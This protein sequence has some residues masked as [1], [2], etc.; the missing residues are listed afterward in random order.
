VGT[1]IPTTYEARWKGV[2][3]TAPITDSITTSFLVLDEA[4]KKYLRTIYNNSAMFDTWIYTIEHI[5]TNLHAHVALHFTAKKF[6]K[7]RFL[8]SLQKGFKAFDIS[9]YDSRRLCHLRSKNYQEIQGFI[10][11][12]LNPYF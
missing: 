5:G 7:N 3:T 1:N 11:Y 4:L 2:T 12:I 9:L 6:P 10:Q 8:P